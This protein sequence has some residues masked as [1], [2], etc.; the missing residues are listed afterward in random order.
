LSMRRH[1]HRSFVR[2]QRRS[3]RRGAE[4]PDYRHA[5]SRRQGVILDLR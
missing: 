5:P 4:I 2:R 1:R 3:T